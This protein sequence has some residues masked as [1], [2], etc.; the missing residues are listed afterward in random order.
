[1]RVVLVGYDKAPSESGTLLARRLTEKGHLAQTFFANGKP[2]G[3]TQE[4]VEQAVAK[5]D[6]LWCGMSSSKF[7][8][9]EFA[10]IENAYTCGVPVVLFADT[11]GAYARPHTLYPAIA[12]M[13]VINALEVKAA[14]KLS[15][16]LTVLVTGAPSWEAYAYPKWKRNVVRREL[17]IPCDNLVVI[18]AGSKTANINLY[19]FGLAC[20]ALALLSHESEIIYCPHPGGDP[21]DLDHYYEAAQNAPC[22]AQVIERELREG[23][24]V[25]PD[26][27]FMTSSQV[28]VAADIVITA[29]SSIGIEAG[30]QRKPVINI[31]DDMTLAWRM[32]E[33]GNTE[34]Q[35]DDLGVSVRFAGTP[36]E[37]VRCIA[38]LRTEERFANM[39]AAQERV[40]V[41]PLYQGEAADKMIVLLERCM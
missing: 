37:L 9:I 24:E 21:D 11:Y 28:L 10:A 18:C 15:P 17:D 4:E 16:H 22:N 34:W 32:R 38:L 33:N 8:A 14:Q 7:S 30:Y 29:F 13:A 36:Q 41:E 25:L 5:A 40:Y 2:P 6:A 12:G 20:S 31:G 39:R 26:Q 23:R 27:E 19:V 3:F 1:M 35:P